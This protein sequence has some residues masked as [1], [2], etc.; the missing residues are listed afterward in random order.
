[1]RDKSY[2]MPTHQ[3]KNLPTH[4]SYSMPTHQ[5][6]NMPTHQSDNMPIVTIYIKETSIRYESYEEDTRVTNMK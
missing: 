5:S 4:Q 3:S 6:Y 1:M 2:N